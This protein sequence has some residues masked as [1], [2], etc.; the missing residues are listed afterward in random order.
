M[1]FREA[2][3]SGLLT[4][5]IQLVQLLLAQGSLLMM[6]HVT[7]CN[8]EYT[9]DDGAMVGNNSQSVYIHTSGKSHY[10]AI[11]GYA[12]QSPQTEDN[13]TSTQTQ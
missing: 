6:S 3:E 11:S 7:S 9:S 13:T 8:V 12:M 10:D 1:C 4:L 2:E 5:S